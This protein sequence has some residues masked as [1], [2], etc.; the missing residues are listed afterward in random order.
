MALV[1]EPS[2]PDLQV[3]E[4]EVAVVICAFLA[5]NDR[6][7]RGFLRQTACPVWHIPVLLSVAPL[8]RRLVSH[9]HRGNRC[10]R[11]W[12]SL[13]GRCAKRTRRPAAWDSNPDTR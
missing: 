1:S 10:S 9:G 5:A 3:S 11:E 4:V 8:P 7:R 13:A 12:T 6:Q 2:G